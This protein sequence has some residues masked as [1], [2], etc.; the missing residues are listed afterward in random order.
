LQPDIDCAGEAENG[1]QVLQLLREGDYDLLLLDMTMDGLSGVDLIRCVRNLK[2]AL[3]IIALSMHNVSQLALHAIREGANG[4][5]TKG[6]EPEILLAAIKKV[7][8]GREIY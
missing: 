4:Y 1:E 8:N 2:P 6:S 7:A 5:I 3:P